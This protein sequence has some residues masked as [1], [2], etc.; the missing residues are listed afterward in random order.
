MSLGLGGD[1][2]N[3]AA[4]VSRRQG[5]QRQN[6]RTVDVAGRSVRAFADALY[7]FCAGFSWGVYP[8]K[9]FNPVALYPRAALEGKS[10][11]ADRIEDQRRTTVLLKLGI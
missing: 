7:I 9:Q 3:F 6:T 1:E 4:A 10:K 11:S 8:L 2:I 5:F